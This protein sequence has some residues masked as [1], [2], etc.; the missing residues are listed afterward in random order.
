MTFPKIFLSMRDPK[1]HTEL[2]FGMLYKLH[3]G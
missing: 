3:N 1:E 2:H